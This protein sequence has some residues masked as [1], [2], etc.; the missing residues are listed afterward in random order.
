MHP[1]FYLVF[2]NNFDLLAKL[3]T[4]VNQRPTAECQDPCRRFALV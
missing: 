2:S 3:I 1:A 4:A